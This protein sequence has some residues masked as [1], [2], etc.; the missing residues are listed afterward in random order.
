MGSWDR[1]V[2]PYPFSRAI[3][4]YGDP[5]SIARHEDVEVA[6]KRVEEAMNKLAEEAEAYWQPATGNRRP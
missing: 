6:R 4:L 5:I 1:M 2:V 3:F